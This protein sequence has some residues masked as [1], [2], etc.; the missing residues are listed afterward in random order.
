MLGGGP[1]GGGGISDWLTLGGGPGGGGGS[2]DGLMFGGGLA[3]ARAVLLTVG[4]S[5]CRWSSNCGDG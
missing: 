3:G 1:D 4:G 2:S 5:Y